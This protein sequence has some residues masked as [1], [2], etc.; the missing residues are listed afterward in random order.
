M[1]SDVTAAADLG[2]VE[3][4]QRVKEPVSPP[5]N[6]RIQIEVGRT[7]ENIRSLSPE[8]VLYRSIHAGCGHV[9]I[10]L[11]GGGTRR[12]CP[13]PLITGQFMRILGS[14]TSRN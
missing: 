8:V 4:V 1:S 5:G 3:K 2:E 7:A 12:G 6:L 9:G 11:A 13:L 14:I 10:E